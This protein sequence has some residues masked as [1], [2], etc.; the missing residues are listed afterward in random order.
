MVSRENLCVICGQHVTQ[1]LIEGITTNPEASV[2]IVGSNNDG[3][4]S[5]S[6][7]G[8]LFGTGSLSQPAGGRQTSAD[9]AKRAYDGIRII[10]VEVR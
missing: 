10:G 2:P 7:T 9:T 4:G 8:G 5:N 1:V 6:Q 3:D